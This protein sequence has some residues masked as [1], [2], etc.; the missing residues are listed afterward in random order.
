[1]HAKK[2]KYHNLDIIGRLLVSANWCYTLINL[3]VQETTRSTVSTWL[4]KIY[5]TIPNLH[6][7]QRTG[8][9]YLSLSLQ[10]LVEIFFLPILIGSI[11]T[12]LADT[13]SDSVYLSKEKGIIIQE[14]ICFWKT[15]ER[16]LPTLIPP[17]WFP[18][19]WLVIQMMIQIYFSQILYPYRTIVG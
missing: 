3:D 5:I 9:T 12:S 1:M 14:S 16:S 6:V 13:T 8:G 15:F 18:P 4:Y 2:R 19:V 10:S 7:H 11:S 17:S